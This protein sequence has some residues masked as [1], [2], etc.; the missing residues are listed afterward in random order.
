MYRCGRAINWLVIFL[1]KLDQIASQIQPGRRLA[2]W[3]DGGWLGGGWLSGGWLG[4]GWLGGGWLCGGCLD[5][6]W[7]FLSVSFGVI[8]ERV[9]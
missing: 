3:L 5:G 7:L 8:Y 6:G 9:I 4:G 1:H 2:A